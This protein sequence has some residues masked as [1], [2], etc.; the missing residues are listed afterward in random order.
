VT[1][2]DRVI[3]SSGGKV[4]AFAIADRSTLGRSLD[5]RK[6]VKRSLSN[7]DY[8]LI[9]THFALYTL[10]ALDLLGSLPL[11]THFHGPWALESKAEGAG[12]LSTWGKWAIEQLVYQ[13]TNG[14]IVLSEAFRQILHQHYHV[15]LDKIF[16]VGGGIDT[17]AFNVG[18]TIAEAR[19]KM[20]WQQDRRIILC[21]RRLVQR[22][23]LES[24]IAAIALVR[25]K[26][27]DVL[28]LIAGKGAISEVLRSQIQE[29]QLENH[30][31]LLG[32]VAD[33]DLAIAYRAAELSIVPTVSLEG[34]G[35]IVIESLAAGTPVLGTPIGGIPEILQPLSPDLVLAGT[36]V[37]QLA[38]GLIEALSGERQIP[39]A[40]ACQDY[41]RQHYDWQAIAEQMRSVYQQVIQKSV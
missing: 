1:G 40:E 8:D 27:P 23:G 19:S 36:K 34:F 35:L 32:F 29:L 5:L 14:F 28:L 10:P 9:A 2:S 16:V 33:Q 24:L 7:S 31:Q 38:Q 20:G 12:W 11:V 4:T 17:A 25:K 30:V 41:V 26:H 13:R 37:E 18:L 15:P 3:Q 21:V 22:M 39:D 6:A